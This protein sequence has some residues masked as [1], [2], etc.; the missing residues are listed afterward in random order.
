M[1]INGNDLLSNVIVFSG[2]GGLY[3]SAVKTSRT[4]SK[5]CIV[6]SSRALASVTVHG[7]IGQ[8]KLR[9]RNRKRVSPACSASRVKAL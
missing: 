5:S 9:R 3:D 4:D 6:E 2:K 8:H 1:V 7:S